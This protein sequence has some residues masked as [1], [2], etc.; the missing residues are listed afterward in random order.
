MTVA[1]SPL[2]IRSKCAILG[3]PGV[4][5]TALT[6]MFHS[7]GTQYPKTYAMTL[8]ADIHTKTVQIPD[9]T[10]SVE[11]YLMDIGG[12]DLFMDLLDKYILDTTCFALVFDITS[13]E[14]FSGLQKWIGVIRN[15]AP[16]L[17]DAP[18]HGVLIG[19]KLEQA[20]RRVVST[21][22]GEEFAKVAGLAYFET[23]AATNTDVEAPFYYLSAAAHEYFLECVSGFKTISDAIS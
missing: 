4:G 23:S 22:E 10:A 21:R 16:Y 15:K 7:D 11:L 5:K 19:N 1:S 13:R 20:S 3:P 17:K 8:H 2:T 14:S 6:Q 12:S 18:S 9:T